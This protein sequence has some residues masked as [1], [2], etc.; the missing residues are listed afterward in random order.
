MF[1]L[2]CSDI[3]TAVV[4]HF[5]SMY[6]IKWKD[7]FPLKELKYPPSFDGRAVCYPSS[8]ILKDYLAWRQV[9][10][11]YFQ[12]KFPRLYFLTILKQN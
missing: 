11:E 3:V 12:Y 4:S 9:D 6:V 10:C 8:E 5:T 1:Q 2:F 7:F